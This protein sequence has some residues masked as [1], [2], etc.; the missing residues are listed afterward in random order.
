VKHTTGIPHSSTGQAIVERANRTMKEYLAKQKQN[1]S[2]EVASRLSKVLFTPNYLCLAEG[3]EE[4]VVEIRHLAVK[5]GK[6]QAV[7][8][9]YVYHRNMQTGEWQGP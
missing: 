4:P 9:L 1:D 5:E 8:E 6:P 2:I 3:R 7:P